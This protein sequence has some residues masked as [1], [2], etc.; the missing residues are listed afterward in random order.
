M[1]IMREEMRFR[2]TSQGGLLD[3]IG[4]SDDDDRFVVGCCY[5]DDSGGSGLCM[6]V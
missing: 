4:C 2:R 3:K 1:V 5:D 6:V